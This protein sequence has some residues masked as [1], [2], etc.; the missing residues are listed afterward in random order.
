M[1]L[2]YLNLKIEDQV[3]VLKQAL[4]NKNVSEEIEEEADEEPEEEE[5]NTIMKNVSFA[6][7]RW[8]EKML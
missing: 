1:F 3:K 7:L 5:L 4:H 8:R 2:I 6:A